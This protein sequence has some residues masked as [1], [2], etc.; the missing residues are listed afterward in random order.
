MIENCNFWLPKQSEIELWRGLGDG[1]SGVLGYFEQ[2]WRVLGA[3]L[4]C[5]GCVLERQRASW[6]RLGV[7]LGLLGRILERFWEVLEAFWNHF[8]SIFERFLSSSA[9]NENSKKP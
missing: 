4:A 9:I 5:F 3:S 1:L 7:I 2:T 6:R 8:E